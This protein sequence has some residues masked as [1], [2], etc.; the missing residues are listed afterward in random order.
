MLNEEGEETGSAGTEGNLTEQN[1]TADK[2]E[3][4]SGTGHLTPEQLATGTYS[5]YLTALERTGRRSE[6][7]VPHIVPHIDHGIEH[8]IHKGGGGQKK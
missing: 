3:K 5:D 1:K 8:K 4:P 6:G 7:I 2:E